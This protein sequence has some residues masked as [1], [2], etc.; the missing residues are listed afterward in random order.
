MEL[1]PLY[2][3]LLRALKPIEEDKERQKIIKDLA[4]KIY[5]GVLHTAKYST[6]QF[7]RHELPYKEID[8]R[9]FLETFYRV[10]MAEISKELVRLFPDCSV[11]YRVLYGENFHD[12]TACEEETFMLLNY[13][14]IHHCIVIDWSQDAPFKSQ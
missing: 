5:H 11:D 6:Q 12:V 13:D 3:S 10:N 9:R 14:T 1:R 8:G 2:R 4:H 7:Y